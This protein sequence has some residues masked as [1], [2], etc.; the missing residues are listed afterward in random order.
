MTGF[1]IAL[2]LVIFAGLINGSFATP[3]KFVKEWDYE[4]S[5][6]IFGL[7]A[8]FIL[9]LITVFLLAPNALMAFRFLPNNKILVIILGGLIFG[10]GQIFLTKA[11]DLIGIG[12]TFIINISI[13]AAGT[14]LFSLFFQTQSNSASEHYNVFRTIAVFV[15]LIAI[16]IAITCKILSKKSS[17]EKRIT[18]VDGCIFAIIA[19]V[20]TVGQGLTYIYVNPSIS[21]IT[22]SVYHIDGLSS[23]II[24]W[25]YIF[26]IAFISYF[27]YFLYLNYR[28]GS[29]SKFSSKVAGK[30]FFLVLSMS[31][32][33]W[34]SIVFYS[35]AAKF[36]EEVNPIF[37][38]S[39]WAVFM[40]FIVVGAI[41]WSL[42]L[43]EWEGASKSTIL[44]LINS[45][46]LF[47]IAVIMISFSIHFSYFTR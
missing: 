4:N 46:A 14:S 1:L 43:K 13:G 42:S 20:S 34:L 27:F 11:L 12:L 36:V 17:T 8:F 23:N 21:S 18:M 6:L 3:L 5:W 10:I 22:E 39:L 25:V 9:P 15:F 26:I 38:V 47:I 2:S 31:I 33:Y 16:T 41:A 44:L 28:N 7:L 24:C 29:F 32:C 40:I 37:L 19:G 45:L 30:N 35:R